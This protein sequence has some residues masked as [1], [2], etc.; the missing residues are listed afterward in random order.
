M[1]NSVHFKSLE[2]AGTIIYLLLCL[3]NKI[4]FHINKTSI[5]ILLNLKILYVKISV[6]ALI[7]KSIVYYTNKFCYQDKTHQN[8]NNLFTFMHS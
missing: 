2:I 5:S 4:C 6:I 7:S 3:K 1:L 8:V